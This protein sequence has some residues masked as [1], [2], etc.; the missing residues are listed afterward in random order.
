VRLGAVARDSPLPDEPNAS[1]RGRRAR[2]RSPRTGAARGPRLARDDRPRRSSRS[3]ALAR[4]SAVANRSATPGAALCT[5]PCRWR[6]ASQRQRRPMV[7]ITSTRTGPVM[8]LQR[9][10]HPPPLSHGCGRP[11]QL[12]RGARSGRRGCVPNRPRRARGDVCFPDGKQTRSRRWREPPVSAP[13]VVVSLVRAG[14]QRWRTSS[15]HAERAPW[16]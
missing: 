7:L 9:D 10:T 5:R 4:G 14:G 8:I 15:A 12:R 3:T 16:R 1:T 6:A 13:A 11:Q 2:R